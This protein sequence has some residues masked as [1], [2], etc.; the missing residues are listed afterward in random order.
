MATEFLREKIN[1]LNNMIQSDEI[2]RF[3]N[4]M[5]IDAADASTGDS[6]VDKAMKDQAQ[7]CKSVVMACDCRLKVYR[8]KLDELQAEL[9]AQTK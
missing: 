2:Q 7:N 1:T 4:Q 3:Q 8:A 5:I 9:D 6:Q